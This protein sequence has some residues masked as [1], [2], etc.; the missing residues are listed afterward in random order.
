MLYIP[1]MLQ[2]NVS[3]P[4]AHPLC[5]TIGITV[6]HTNYRKL[7][8]LHRLQKRLI[9]GLLSSCP[10][11]SH[12]FHHADCQGPAITLCIFPVFCS[13]SSSSVEIGQEFSALF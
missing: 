5:D 13:V 3:P 11:F 4:S 9:T 8:I 2:V 12:A 1:H 7:H 6:S 10:H